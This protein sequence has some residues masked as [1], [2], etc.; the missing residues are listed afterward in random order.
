MDLDLFVDK[1]VLY[2]KKAYLKARSI[3]GKKGIKKYTRK[4]RRLT[5]QFQEIHTKML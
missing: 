2:S 5:T 1:I 3:G 4:L